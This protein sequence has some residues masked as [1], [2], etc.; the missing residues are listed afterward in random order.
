[1][2]KILGRQLTEM[3]SYRLFE[4]ADSHQESG[5]YSPPAPCR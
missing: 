2:K 5:G 4:I 3:S 1:M